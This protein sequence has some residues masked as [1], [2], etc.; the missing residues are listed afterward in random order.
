MLKAAQITALLMVVVDDAAMRV[1]LELPGE[2]LAYA[3]GMEVGKDVKG[4]IAPKVQKVILASVLHMEEVDVASTLLARKVHKEAPCS[5]RHMGV[6][7]DALG[8]AAPKV[9]KGA[10]PSVRDTVVVSVAHSRVVVSAQRVFMVGPCSVLLM[11]VAKDVLYRSA[12]RVQEDGRT[13]VF[14]MVGES[15]ASSRVV[16]KVPRDALIFARLMVEG[17]GVHGVRQTLILALVD[18]HVIALHGE[19]LVSVLHT[20]HCCKI[21]G[22]MVVV[23]WG[24]LL[25]T[26]CSTSTLIR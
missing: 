17:S 12:L 16:E 22:F 21:T 15:A 6:A 13:T 3:S 9:Q 11:G 5:A 1:A 20:V 2:N 19:E 23:Q 25:P 26:L 7:R 10:H 18:P 14:A 4:R 24:L 8:L